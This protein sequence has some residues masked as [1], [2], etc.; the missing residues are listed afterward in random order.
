MNSKITEN[1]EVLNKTIVSTNEGLD[2]KITLRI[3]NLINKNL[4]IPGVIDDPE[5]INS[6]K[7]APSSTLK[8][9]ILDRIEVNKMVNKNISVINF[10]HFYR[11]L[12]KKYRNL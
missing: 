1:S 7:N 9:Y 11:I 8:D 3:D 6:S 12:N 5:G 10:V 4:K 2:K